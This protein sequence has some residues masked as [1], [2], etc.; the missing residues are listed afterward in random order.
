MSKGWLKAIAETPALASEITVVGFVDIAE[1]AARARAS[2]FGK[3]DAYVGVDIDAALDLLKPD[4][5]FDVVV[6]TA[7]HDLV[8]KALAHGCHVLTEKPMAASMEE[9][10][11]LV[12][13]AKAAGRI[14]AVVQNRRFIAGVRRIK[15]LAKATFTP[16]VLSDVGSF[17]GL[18][19][20][21]TAT[22]KEPVLVSSADGVGTKLKVAFMANRHRTIGADL[23]NHCVND[24]LVQGATPLFFLYYLAT[25]RLSPDV[26]EQIVEGLASRQLVSKLLRAGPELLVRQRR[27]LRLHR[28]D[29]SNIRQVALQASVVGGAENLFRESAEHEGSVPLKT[30]RERVAG[31]DFEHLWRENAAPPRRPT[32][33]RWCRGPAHNPRACR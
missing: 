16:G 10:R 23:V 32:A 21:D 31:L 18:F 7:R 17:G 13:R 1:A 2:E 27:E 14:H 5:L 33:P 19:R 29:R 20:L 3:P 28:I 22:W 26:A 9:A 25:G 30:R 6:P 11:D 24:I 15:R 4:M 12:A 8:G